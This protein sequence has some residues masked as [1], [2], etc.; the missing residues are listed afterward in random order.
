MTPLIAHHAQA[1]SVKAAPV[2]RS[3]AH[4]VSCHLPRSAILPVEPADS[5]AVHQCVPSVLAPLVGTSSPFGRQC[6]PPFLHSRRRCSHASRQPGRPSQPGTAGR[7]SSLRTLRGSRSQTAPPQPA[8]PG[9]YAARS[10]PMVPIPHAVGQW[11]LCLQQPARRGT[12]VT[13]RAA[14]DANLLPATSRQHPQ[15]RVVP[16]PAHPWP[17]LTVSAAPGADLRHLG[18]RALQ[19]TRFAPAGNQA[20]ASQPLPSFFLPR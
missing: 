14:C 1:G 10:R 2:S 3:P 18:R 11:Y 8:P 7:R 5:S 13:V 4:S 15:G 12:S 6:A 16:R 20:A 17:K 19:C 9:T